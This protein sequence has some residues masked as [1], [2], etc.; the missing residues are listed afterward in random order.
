MRNSNIYSGTKTLESMNQAKFYNQWTFA[1]FNECLKGDILE[2]GCG[3]GNFT[4]ILSGYGKITAIDIDQS[5]I[6]RFNKDKNPNISAGYGDI[7][8]G[9]Y[10]FQKKTFDT[11]I[12]INVLE[13][14]KDDEKA[15]QNMHKLLKRNGKLILLVP[16]HKFLYG[17]IDRAI[18]HF[19]RY[20]PGNLKMILKQ[21][22]FAIENSRR[23][24]LLGAFGWFIAGRV[25]KEKNIEE[26]NIKLFNFFAP[27]ILRLEDLIEPPVGTSLL[28]I[29]KKL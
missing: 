21:N 14:I 17:E 26:R 13:H 6:D 19:R 2:I 10:F 27:F 28:I 3:I 12:C 11:I 29:A 7:E 22:G 16:I 24:N 25:L 15:L 4:N 23:L 9:E 18:N 8:K 20:S 1:K 5:L